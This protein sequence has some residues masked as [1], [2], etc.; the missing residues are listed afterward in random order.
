MNIDGRSYVKFCERK[1]VRY[2]VTRWPNKCTV[3]A[4]PSNIPSLCNIINFFKNKFKC[5]ALN[6]IPV[7][8][9]CTIILEL[10]AL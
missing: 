1:Y 10:E 9:M 7:A 3:R 2:A 6:I 4:Y 8:H 5:A